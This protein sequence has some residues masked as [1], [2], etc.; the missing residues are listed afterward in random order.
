MPAF[1]ETTGNRGKGFIH[2]I[3]NGWTREYKLCPPAVL[4]DENVRE[5]REISVLTWRLI[6]GEAQHLQ[7]HP[8]ATTGEGFYVARAAETAIV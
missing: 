8:T 6:K 4:Q 5:V 7:H 3:E 2:K 1:C